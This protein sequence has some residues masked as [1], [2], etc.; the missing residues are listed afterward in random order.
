MGKL[1]DNN[2]LELTPLEDLIDIAQKYSKGEI[3]QDELN[4]Y[5]HDMVVRSYIPIL[6]KMQI[7]MSI[8]TSYVYRDTNTQEVKIAELYKNIFFYGILGGYGLVDC[9]KIELN[10]YANYDLLYPIFGAQIKQYCKDD[11]EVLK[12][13]IDDSINLYGI[14]NISSAIENVSEEAI[15]KQVA[16]NKET[17]RLLDENKDIIENLKELATMNNPAAKQIIEEIKKATITRINK[18]DEAE[19]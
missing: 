6:E 15:E 12:S 10:T 8:L 2:N 5:W 17:V 19:Q 14:T 11:F 7:A 13:F 4:D 18:K 3:N 9:S 1:N 16:E